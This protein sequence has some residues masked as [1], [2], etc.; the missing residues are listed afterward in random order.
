[1]DYRVVFDVA[2]SGYQGWKVPAQVL[3][4]VGVGAVL[5]VFRA[6]I[7]GRLPRFAT[8]YNV[9][10]FAV[11][12]LAVLWLLISLFSTY[13]EYTGLL[14]AE[15]TGQA[16]VAEGPVTDFKTIPTRGYTRERFC[17]QKACFEY[18]DDVTTSA[19]HTTRLRGGPVREGLPVRVTYT[20]DSIIRLE[21]AK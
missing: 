21:V 11:A 20:G 1:M 7:A 5:V 15:Q 14:S 13:I 4:A 18:S 19:F 16:F 9:V 17:V 8:A 3:W 12:G 10:A 6:R 2:E